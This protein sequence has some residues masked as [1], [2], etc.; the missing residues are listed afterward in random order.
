MKRKASWELKV[1]DANG[2]NNGTMIRFKP[3]SEVFIGIKNNSMPAEYYINI[4]RRQQCCT[5]DLKL[6]LFH[7]EIGK[8]IVLRYD[9][10]I[11]QTL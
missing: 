1:T 5:M 11:K 8:D 2:R 3:D 6:F 7:E 9:N 4:L 10:G